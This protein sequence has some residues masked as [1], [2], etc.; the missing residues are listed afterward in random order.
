ERPTGFP[1]L[2]GAAPRGGPTRRRGGPP[3][4]VLAHAIATELQAAGEQVTLLA[5]LDSHPDI[6]VTDFRA[7]IREALAELGIGAHALLPEDG[8][9]HD[10]S[11]EA[12]AALHATIPPDM[13]V[14]TPERVRRIYRSAVRSAELIAE[15][16]P[17][18]FRGRLD[19]FSAAGHET[20]A[21]NWYPLVEGRVEDH[22][23]GVPHDQM[24]SP[25]ALADIGPALSR[26]L[27]P[28][29]GDTARKSGLT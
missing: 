10:L 29:T 16:R 25:E 26:L 22:P 20:A 21:Q 24:T 7:A 23:I 1:R 17:A 14:L 19:Y 2:P 12:L 5:M 3:G 13:A 27:D 4:G 28:R 6:D 9:I 15:H 11:E 18:V 8:D